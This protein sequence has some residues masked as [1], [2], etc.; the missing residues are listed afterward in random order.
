MS[1]A[2]KAPRTGLSRRSLLKAGAASIAGGLGGGEA[3][4]VAA[5]ERRDSLRG[6][7]SAEDLVLVNGKIH[8]MDDR[9]RVV[10]AV[11]ISNGR[12]VEVGHTARSHG[13]DKRVINLRGRTVVPGIID[14][15]NHIVLMGNRPGYHTP[16]ENAYSIADV[17]ATYKAR[18]AGIPAGAWITTMYAVSVFPP[19][20]RPRT[21]RPSSPSPCPCHKAP[22]VPGLPC[23]AMRRR[24]AT[25]GCPATR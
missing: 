12:F 7:R 19:P 8:T 24:A 21:T 20:Q 17:Q 4:M 16:L 10:S 11:T 5:D 1:E 6:D 23:L 13:S 18:A 15:H 2:D 25:L 22:A 14:N 9:N 3:P